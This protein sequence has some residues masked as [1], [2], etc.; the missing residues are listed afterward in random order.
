MA[1]FRLLSIGVA[2]LLDVGLF[3]VFV[4]VLVFGLPL[5]LY[6]AFGGVIELDSFTN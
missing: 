1:F 4:F 6:W 5:L 3:H 2:F